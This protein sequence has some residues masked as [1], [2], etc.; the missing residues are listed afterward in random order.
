MNPPIRL[1]S[2]IAE[3]LRVARSQP[4]ATTVTLLLAGAVAAVILATTGQTVQA[5]HQ[6]LS[7]IDDAGTRGIVI[8]DRNDE[9]FLQP[10]ALDRIAALSGVEW[11]IGLGPAVDSRNA[12]LGMAGDRAPVRTVYGDLPDVIRTDPWERRPGTALVG[13]TAQTTLGLPLPV[14][15][16]TLTDRRQIS[17]VGAFTAGDPL[18]FLNRSVVA[19]PD[20]TNPSPKIRS[21]LVLTERPDQVAAVADAALTV[22]GARDMGS[23]G[24][25]TSEALADIRAA[26]AGELGRYGRNLVT[27]VLGVGLLLVALNLYGSVTTR[28]RDFGRR[29]ALGASRPTIIALVTIQA[30]VLSL[31]GAVLG[32]AVATALVWN[33]TGLSP[34][35]AFT[36]AIV[37]LTSLAAGVAALP[38][39]VIAA[40]RDPLAVLRIP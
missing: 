26:V 6:V 34:D 20:P 8:T 24:I 19:A 9:A 33:W 1:R 3:A 30:L 27:I 2:L 36:G 5:E 39:A 16:L 14:G 38:P 11:V 37:V 12:H 23:V 18:G 10:D 25:E 15:G 13:P 32:A 31:A 22:L 21:I 35:W 7:R 28:R 4:A 29:R 17:V 40:Y